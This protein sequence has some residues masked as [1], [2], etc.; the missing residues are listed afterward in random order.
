[1]PSINIV[2]PETMLREPAVALAL[3][4]LTL[5]LGGHSD[6]PA[7]GTD[8][9]ARHPEAAA[10]HRAA[11]A[12][13]DPALAARWRAYLDGLSENS[14]RFLTLLEQRGRLTLEEALEQLGLPGGKALGGITGPIGRWTPKNGFSVPYATHEDPHGVRYWVWT[15]IAAA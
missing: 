8:R 10:P 2:V 15:G 1:M 12:A 7:V 5:A 4:R 6:G 14:R 11:A 3:T 9:P 13:V